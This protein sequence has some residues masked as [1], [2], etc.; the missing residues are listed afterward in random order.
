MDSETRSHGRGSQLILSV[1][2]EEKPG[3]FHRLNSYGI[4][5]KKGTAEPVAGKEA[6]SLW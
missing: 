4:D 2:Y 1:G 3:L 6:I 5:R